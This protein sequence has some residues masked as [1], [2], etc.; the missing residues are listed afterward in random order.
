[1][2]L[3]EIALLRSMPLFAPLPAPA[4]EGLAHA[5]EPVELPAGTVVMRMGEEGDRFYAIAEGEVEVSRG[6]VTLARLARGDGFGEIALLEDVPRT[7]TVTA[8]TDVRLYALEKGPF[9]TT[10][11]TGTPLPP[12]VGQ[13]P[14]LAAPRRAR[15]GRRRSRSRRLTLQRALTPRATSCCAHRAWRRRARGQPGGRVARACGASS[16]KAATPADSVGRRGSRGSL[17]TLVRTRSATITPALRLPW[18]TIANSSPPMRKIC[19]PVR[20]WRDRDGGDVAQDM[21]AGRM[22]LRVV[23]ALEMIDVEEDERERV[24]R[25]RPRREHG[26][27]VLLERA[28]V[29]QAGQGIPASEL[30]PA[31]H[32]VDARLEL[33]LL[34]R[35]SDVVVGPCPQ[36]RTRSISSALKASGPNTRKPQSRQVDFHAVNVR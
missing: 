24:S 22:S 30:G 20:S 28:S 3:V 4:I 19:S 25:L 7:A 29:R 26:V 32:G 1:M 9:V 21:I 2:P 27:E 8:L 5:L 11:I 16:G 31:H 13:R 33:V 15:A 10:A 34:K 17:S 14:R 36:P 18:T 35:L 12:Q 23:D 6:G